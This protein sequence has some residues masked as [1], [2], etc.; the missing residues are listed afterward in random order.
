MS[1][2]AQHLQLA[3]FMVF[4]YLFRLGR[5]YQMNLND[6]SKWDNMVTFTPAL[7]GSLINQVLI[8]L[9]INKIKYYYS[10]LYDG[11]DMKGFS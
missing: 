3:K 4:K 9:M 2:L 1:H 11:L 7:F 10:G 8:S 5:L 6:E